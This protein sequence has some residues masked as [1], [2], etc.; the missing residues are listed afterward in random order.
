MTT[1]INAITDRQAQILAVTFQLQIAVD[2][3]AMAISWLSNDVRTNNLEREMVT[4]KALA[5]E[6]KEDLDQLQK[7]I[8]EEFAV[9][10]IPGEPAND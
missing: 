5:D 8:W 9:G 4:V 1:T 3:L 2:S 6:A 10:E 7:I